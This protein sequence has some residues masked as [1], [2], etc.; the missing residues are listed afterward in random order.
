MLRKVR[1]CVRCSGV[2]IQMI[3]TAASPKL[4]YMQYMEPLVAKE[5]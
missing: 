5:R 3:S 2:K 1:I 4:V